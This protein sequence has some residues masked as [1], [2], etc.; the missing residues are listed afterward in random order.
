LNIALGA[1]LIV[2]VTGCDWDKTHQLVPP[3][4]SRHTVVNDLISS[5]LTRVPTMLLDDHHVY[6]KNG[7]QY[8]GWAEGEKE[9][10]PKGTSVILCPPTGRER[11]YNISPDIIG[12]PGYY[13]IRLK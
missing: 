12:N 2:L 7:S 11:R 3:G 8:A 9:D 1:V 5:S 6:R 10:Y 13:F 4:C